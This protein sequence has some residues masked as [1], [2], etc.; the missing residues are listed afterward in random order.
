M[1]CSIVLDYTR[2]P[3]GAGMLSQI[4]GEK[5]SFKRVNPIKLTADKNK[6]IVSQSIIKQLQAS[7]IM[8]TVFLAQ[9]KD[10]KFIWAEP[11][12]SVG[13]G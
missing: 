10:Y 7:R 3:Q 11:L 2:L 5:N 13:G 6:G 8:R 9:N 12:I 1:Y 4:P